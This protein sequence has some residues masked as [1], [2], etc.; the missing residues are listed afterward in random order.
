MTESHP[1]LPVLGRGRPGRAPQRR[2]E[3]QESREPQKN[4]TGKFCAAYSALGNF[5]RGSLCV[6][7]A[8]RKGPTGL[9][10]FWIPFRGRC[11]LRERRYCPFLRL[12][13]DCVPSSEG[14]VLNVAI[15]HP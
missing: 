10:E 2:Q 3:R 4:G 1:P 12:R 6:D 5:M 9:A 11:D 8:D 13:L 15:C 7:V 14:A